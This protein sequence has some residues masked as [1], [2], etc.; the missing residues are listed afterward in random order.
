MTGAAFMK[1]GH[2]DD[3]KNVRAVLSV[4]LNRLNMSWAD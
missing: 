1:L 4:R 2:S 3:V